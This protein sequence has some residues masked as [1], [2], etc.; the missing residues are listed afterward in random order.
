MGTIQFTN[1]SQTTLNGA[2][3]NAQVTMN[4]SSAVGFPAALASGDFFM[5]AID[6][7]IVK[8][9]AYSN[10]NLTW[11]IV[12]GQSG[13]TPAAHD[14]LATI[15]NILDQSSMQYVRDQVGFGPIANRPTGIALAGSKYRCSDSQMEFMY[16]G[17]NWRH[18]VFGCDCGPVMESAIS[19]TRALNG[20]IAIGATS[21]VVNAAPP[22]DI[23][24]PFY[25][26]IDTEMIR[27]TAMS[28]DKLTW[29][30]VRGMDLTAAAVHG[31]AATVTIYH[32]SMTNQGVANY[33]E[34]YG[35]IYI[36]APAVAGDN[37]K[38]MKKP[39]KYAAPWT[40]VMAFIPHMYEVN[41][42]NVGMMLHE[43]ATNKVK[44]LSLG[45][46]PGVYVNGMYW[47]S[48]TTGGTGVTGSWGNVYFR[49]S[50]WVWFFKMKTDGV[51]LTASVS[52]DGG[53]H[54]MDVYTHALNTNAT[55][56]WDNIGFYANPV[57]A[58]VGSQIWCVGWQDYNYAW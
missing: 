35:G 51:N 24:A 27:V 5:A 49:P 37:I 40:S 20:A 1:G 50:P 56:T 38:L 54:W 57:N 36:T 41:Y 17:T 42:N 9:T 31:D 39:L 7:E 26:K 13:T 33:D 2:I 45:N 58:T 25:I 52:M 3:D 48:L 46:N 19:A 6:D 30:I 11:T 22:S 43:S 34:S 23:V 28:P 16:D 12:R 47:A 44:S 15:T 10:A 4:V 8:V 18:V 55:T 53:K 29:T 14:D 32:W 21:M